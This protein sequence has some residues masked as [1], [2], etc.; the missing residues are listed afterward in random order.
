MCRIDHGR[1]VAAA[2]EE[3]FTRKQH[4]AGFPAEAIRNCLATRNVDLDLVDGVV[5]FEKPLIKF[6]RLLETYLARAPRGFASFRMAFPLWIKEKL[7]QKPSLEKA[8]AAFSAS[9]SVEGKLLFAEHH[10]SHAASAF[11]PSPF[12]EAVVAGKPDKL[13]ARRNCVHPAGRGA[14]G[15]GIC[16][17]HLS[18]CGAFLPPLC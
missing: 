9:G 5:F 12:D 18:A 13:G 14:R 1:V 3:R 10:Q 2:Q 6:E 16:P 7:F 8:L 11:F 4:D 15:R 17:R